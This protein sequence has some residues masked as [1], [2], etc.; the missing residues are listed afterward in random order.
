MSQRNSGHARIAADRY[1]TPAWV[2]EALLPHLR[3]A[4]TIWEP[5][6]GSGQMARVLERFAGT[7]ISSD[8]ADG[9]DFLTAAPVD[10]CGIVTN[11]PYTHAVAFI[12]RALSLTA[13]DGVVAML[14]RCDFDHAKTRSHLFAGCSAFAKKIVRT[15]RVK[16]F[17]DSAG[18]PSFNHAWFLW[19]HRHK[20]PPTLAYGPNAA[21]GRHNEIP[22]R[23]V[24]RVSRHPRLSADGLDRPRAS[25]V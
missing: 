14:L 22:S 19:D 5:A 9:Q 12:E 6:A 3:P 8:I 21:G 13:P 16:W 18:Q 11:P 24:R 1:M 10:C 17:E 4:R 25:G 20:G 15:R 23:D 2:T 7:V